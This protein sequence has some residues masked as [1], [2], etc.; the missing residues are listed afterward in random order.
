[1]LARLAGGFELGLGIDNNADPE[2]AELEK[3][4][5]PQ[6]VLSEIERIEQRLGKRKAS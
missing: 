3:E 1:M 5:R 6:D 4:I 2:L